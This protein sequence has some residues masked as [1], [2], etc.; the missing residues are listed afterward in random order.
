MKDQTQIASRAMIVNLHISQWS[1]RKL[2]KQVSEEVATDHGASRDAGNFNKLLLDKAALAPIQTIA[3]AARMY[4]YNNT[5]PWGDNGDR[6]LLASN[7]FDFMAKMREYKQEFDAEVDTL[8]DDYTAHVEQARFR[9]N[10]MFK[11]QDYPSANSVRDRFSLR[12]K[13]RPIPTA[14][15]F[16]VQMSQDEVDTLRDQIAQEL[17]VVVD[18][19]MKSLWEEA[20][21]TMSHLYGRL[22]DPK[23]TFKASTIKNFEEFVERL[24]H[25][26]LTQDTALEEFRKELKAGLVGYTA[27]E[28]RKDSTVRVAAAVETKRIMDKF[29]GAWA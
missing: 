23:A 8:V 4:C 19:A 12:Y 26:N 21:T 27:E 20:R 13:V 22:A 16:R 10:S 25:L 9:L 29:A 14:G 18:E 7:Y 6:V 2:D 11:E 15:D 28:L 3:S 24:P 5:L 17:S 1:G